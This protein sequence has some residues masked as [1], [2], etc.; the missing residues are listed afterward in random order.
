[1]ND[2]RGEWQGR[3]TLTDNFCLWPKEHGQRDYWHKEEQDKKNTADISKFE[4]R[5]ASY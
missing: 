4:S 3:R 2:S 5:R 1:M